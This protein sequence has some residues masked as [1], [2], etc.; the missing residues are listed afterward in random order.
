MGMPAT[1]SQSDTTEVVGAS[2]VRR[3]GW[4]TPAIGFTA[5]LGTGVI[6]KHWEWAA[7]LAIGSAL[8]WL[9]FRL[10]RRGVELFIKAAAARDAADTPKPVPSYL[11]AVLRYGLIGLGVY[12]IFTYLHVPLASLAT[13]LCALAAAIMAASAW[14]IMDSKAL[15]DGE[16]KPPHR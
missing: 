2:T 9:N 4:L 1:P 10:L 7:G 16:K 8:A 6:T 11:G 13:G 5:A 3:I 15:A 14:A 12:A